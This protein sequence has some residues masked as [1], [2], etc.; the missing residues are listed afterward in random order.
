MFRSIAPFVLLNLV[1]NW[2]AF[3]TNGFTDHI[4]NVYYVAVLTCL[5]FLYVDFYT[6]CCMYIRMSVI[7]RAIYI[8]GRL[9]SVWPWIKY[10]YKQHYMSLITCFFFH[11]K[12]IYCK[13]N[14]IQCNTCPCISIN[15]SQ[16]SDG[17]QNALIHGI[18]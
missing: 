14:R 10:I 1:K 18:H 15:E 5:V 17:I 12:L 7:H 13:I 8:T 3:F 4:T 6:V 11:S 9:L 2:V 16:L